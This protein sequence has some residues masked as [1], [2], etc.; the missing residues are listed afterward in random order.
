MACPRTLTDHAC[1]VVGGRTARPTRCV[2][3]QSTLRR[4]SSRSRGTARRWTGEGGAVGGG[5][6]ACAS[7]AAAGSDCI[8]MRAGSPPPLSNAAR[9]DRAC[10]RRHQRLL[11]R[12]CPPPPPPLSA[13][14]PWACC[15]LKWSRGTLPSTRCRNERG[16]GG[17]GSYIGLWG[18]GHGQHSGIAGGAAAWWWR[19][20]RRLA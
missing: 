1:G 5:G 17:K 10:C 20:T 13:G 7:L 15:C 12:P 9:T 16:G 18:E 8:R 3:R 11:C 19:S 2:E 4:S 14:G 6:N